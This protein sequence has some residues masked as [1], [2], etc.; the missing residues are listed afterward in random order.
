MKVISKN[1]SNYQAI[2]DLFSKYT[3]KIIIKSKNFQINPGIM[4]IL[5]KFH[6]F[7]SLEYIDVT[8]E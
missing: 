6:A 1:K 7:K 3:Y 2:F 8:Q 5:T 4:V